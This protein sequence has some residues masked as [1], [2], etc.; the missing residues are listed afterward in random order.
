M[1]PRF[2]RAAHAE[3]L[4][5]VRNGEAR[6]TGLGRELLAEVRRLLD[7]LCNTPNIGE[8]LDGRLRRFPIARFPFAVIYRASGD[9][10]RILAV[11]HRRQKP[12]YWRGRQ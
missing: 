8:P 4:A 11:A 7:L 12:G 2:H 1:T 5:A 9:T 10:L 6:A 3:L